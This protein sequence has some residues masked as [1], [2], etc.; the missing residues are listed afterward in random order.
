MNRTAQ[1]KTERRRRN[2]DALGGKR[3]RLGLTG[4]KDP[5]FEYRWINDEGTRLHDLTVNDDWEVV[6]D[7][8]GTMKEGAS[9]QGAEVSVPVGMGE[10]GRPVRAILVRKPKD[11][12]ED[13][14]RAAQRRIDEKEAGLRS[15]NASAGMSQGESYVPKGGIVIE[16]GGTS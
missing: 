14:K 1:I 12:Y 16:S 9:G 8:N 5:E 6:Q 3:R 11:F 7:R 4:E 13:D 2:T 15:G 10:H